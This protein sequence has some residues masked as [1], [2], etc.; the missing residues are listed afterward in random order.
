M[1][2]SRLTDVAIWGRIPPPIGG[3]AVHVQRLIPYLQKAGVSVHMY[4]VGRATPVHAGVTQVAHRRLRWLFG[5]LLWRS[6]PLHY[7]LSDSTSARFAA[8]C[9]S[10][11]GKSKVVLRIG[12]AS[13]ERAAVSRSLI[14][15]VMVRF[16][17]RN[18]SAVI[19]V[20]ERI[21]DLATS[22][23]A[24]R[25]LHVPGFIVGDFEDKP[26][27]PE[28]SVFL[29]HSRGRV[30]L[31]SGEVQSRESDLYG[32]YTLLDLLECI[33]DLRLIFYAYRI[34][35][36]GLQEDLLAKEIEKRGLK[37]RF[38][39]FRSATDLIS[40]MRCSDLMVRPTA[41]DGDSNAVRE[42]L[43][44]NL[45]VVASDCVN[46]PD[47]VITYPFGDQRAFVGAVVM[48]LD[49]LEAERQRLRSMAKLDYAERIV[50]LFREMLERQL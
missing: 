50:E 12:G 3:M 29:K 18:A 8:V 14:E 44:L 34:T 32:A 28:V 6:E 41:S 33:P 15:R 17:I 20:S 47:G 36:D 25:V 23:G 46:R 45:P 7:V 27:P 9:L 30:V 2:K 37:S 26:A 16:A 38:L 10:F 48:V 1:A 11:F 35:L 49:D 31:A 5:L 19:G 43:H 39:L 4:S 24:K 40:A 21:C 13:L 22:L 42:A